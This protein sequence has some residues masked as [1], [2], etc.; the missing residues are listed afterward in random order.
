M[1]IS[2]HLFTL[3]FPPSHSS[4]ASPLCSNSWSLVSLVVD[5]YVLLWFY[6]LCPVPPKDMVFQPSEQGKCCLMLPSS[7]S[8]QL[9][10]LL[11]IQGYLLQRTLCVLLAIGSVFGHDTNVTW[12]ALNSSS[13]NTL[14]LQLVIVGTKSY[15]TFRL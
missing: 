5:V 8:T 3:P 10:R 7:S 2:L 9:L 11:K 4:P 15:W 14:N 1:K 12:W 6:L 13:C